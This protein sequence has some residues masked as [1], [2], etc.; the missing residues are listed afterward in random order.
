MK[1][2]FEANETND[3]EIGDIN[4]IERK[5]LNSLLLIDF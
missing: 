3:D 5:N 4:E 1:D 2:A